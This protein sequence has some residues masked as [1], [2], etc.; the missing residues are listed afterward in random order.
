MLRHAYAC[1]NL[2]PQTLILDET[3]QS[4]PSLTYYRIAGKFCG[5]KNRSTR[6]TVVFVSK[7]FV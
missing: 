3:L 7:N 2:P 4:C 1:P 6:E 5:V